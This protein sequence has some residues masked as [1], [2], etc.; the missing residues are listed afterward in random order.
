MFIEDKKDK[1]FIPQT[2]NTITAND[3][4]QIK[5][6]IQ[7]CISEAGLTPTKDVIQ[8]PNALRTIAEASSTAASEYAAQALASKNA[9]ET[10]SNNAE[11]SATLAESAKEEA[12]QSADEAAAA[13]ESAVSAH[14]QS[15]SAHADIRTTLAGKAE[16]TALTAHTARTDNPHAVTKAQVGLGNVDNTSDTDKPVSAAVQA[17]LERKEDDE[18][19]YPADYNWPDI[20]P[21]ARPNS[22]VLLAGV[23]A[24]YSAYDNLGFA[25]TCEGGFN[26]FIDGV[27][28]GETY[29]SETQCSIT[30]SQYSATAGFSVTKPQALSA[31]IVQIVPAGGNN[32]TAF[33]CKRVAASGMEQQGVLWAHF[34]ISNAIALADSFYY[35]GVFN[36]PLLTAVTAKED[37]LKILSMGSA[38]GST[39]LAYIAQIDGSGASASSLSFPFNGNNANLSKVRLK[40]FPS[41]VYFRGTFG[42]QSGLKKIKSEGCALSLYSSDSVLQGAGALQ[43]FPDFDWSGCI[44]AKTFLTEAQNIQPFVLDLGYANVLTAFGITNTPNFKGLLVS[45]QAPFTGSS[46]QINVSYTGLDQAALVALF[47]SLPYNVGYT[48]VGSP[49]IQNG[50]A[51]GFSET[52][53]LTLSKGVD[54]SQDFEWVFKIHTPT[55]SNADQR[56]MAYNAGTLCSIYLSGSSQLLRWWISSD[57]NGAHTINSYIAMPADTDI[58]IKAVHQNGVYTLS[59]STDGNIY[60]EVGSLSFTPEGTTASAY[61]DIGVNHTS[62]YS[63]FL[64]SIN[65]ANSYMNVQGVPYFRGTAAMDKTINI[66]GAAGAASL[67]AEQLAIVTG[68]GWTVTR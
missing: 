20:R 31:H 52:N 34:N 39:P 27:Q 36:M 55:S 19:F 13:A 4:N 10:A 28:Y 17:A 59:Y 50:V 21:A 16:Q 45:P 30:W 1:V 65:L 54:I 66:T 46:P 2:E 41:S 11:Q 33:A 7:E 43:T 35:F 68:K 8:L 26:V 62:Y 5:N 64:G 23:K 38:F 48:V 58:F 15:D 25:A 40:N 67:T 9:A 63:P 47:N 44:T 57:S 6:E 32:I 60:T 18:E 61:V 22:I 14:N 29:A 37:M 24:D 12:Q 3:Y 56:I 53:Y 42:G 49:T 51:S